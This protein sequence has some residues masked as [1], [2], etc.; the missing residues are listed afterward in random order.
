M[1]ET[2]TKKANIINSPGTQLSIESFFPCDGNICFLNNR[3]KN[4]LPPLVQANFVA[5]DN[6]ISVSVVIFIE[7][8]ITITEN[9]LNVTWDNNVLRPA[10]YISYNDTNS[11]S[12]TFNGYQ[13]SFTLTSAHLLGM[14]PEIIKVFLWDSDPETS[15][16]TETS[17][18]TGV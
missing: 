4:P 16:G 1:S 11:P 6:D 2:I 5:N 15:R 12:T 8:T 3:G 17:V 9:D 14:K 7:S 10:F 18:Q 13:V